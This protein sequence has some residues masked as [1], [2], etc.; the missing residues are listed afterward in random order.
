[1]Q[2][3]N[4]KLIR[5]VRKHLPNVILIHGVRKQYLVL[6]VILIHGVRKWLLLR[7][8]ILIHGVRKWLL[9]LLM[10]LIHGV[11]KQHLQLLKYGAIVLH[12]RKVPM[13][14]HGINKLELMDQML[15]AAL[16]IEQESVRIWDL[17]ATQI[18]GV[19]RSK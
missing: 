1:M 8:V 12:K 5:G 2:M 6:M 19:A 16:G 3:E 17:V 9:L 4:Q 7:M 13:K 10:I 15:L 11:R 18:H 14:M